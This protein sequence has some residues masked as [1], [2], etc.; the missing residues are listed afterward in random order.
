MRCNQQYK[1]M[2]APAQIAEGMNRAIDNASR[3]YRSARLLF[4][5]ADFPTAASLAVLAIEE[6]GKVSI[7]RNM[8]MAVKSDDLKECWSEYRR[9]L[10]KSRMAGCLLNFHSGNVRLE[11]F[12]SEYVGDND[13][14]KRLD[15]LKQLGFYTDCIKEGVWVSPQDR[16]TKDVAE[17]LIGL[18]D[19]QC[20]GHAVVTT[21]EIELW[22][23]CLSPVRHA[24]YDVMQ[25]GLVEWHRRMVE[26]GLRKDDEGFVKFVTEGLDFM[27]LNA[28]GG[29]FGKASGTAAWLIGKLG[30]FAKRSRCRGG[31]G[32]G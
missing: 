25:K 21:R 28:G 20:R 31:L 23:E 11:D 5:V 24:S 19:V 13:T 9:H 16:I 6:A 18:A 22:R 26:E 8:A 14:S 27:A 3:L 12:R 10:E 17:V 29:S 2:L 32:A 15:D 1:G 30:S 4:D 7:L